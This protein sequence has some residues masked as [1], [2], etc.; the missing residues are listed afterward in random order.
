MQF[1][2]TLGALKVDHPTTILEQS[3]LHTPRH[4]L[5]SFRLIP[6]R[7]LLRQ[8]FM[9]KNFPFVRFFFLDAFLKRRVSD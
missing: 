1:P 6:F 9:I 3:F 7:F 5:H 2:L 4:T 8:I